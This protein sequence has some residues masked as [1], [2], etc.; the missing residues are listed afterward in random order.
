MPTV[1]MR[2]SPHNLVYRVFIIKNESKE[3]NKLTKDA[4]NIVLVLLAV[5]GAIAVIG[6]VSAA[7]LSES[8]LMVFRSDDDRS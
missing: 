2:K 5:I 8:P 1:S 4:W 7:F 3:A 6:F